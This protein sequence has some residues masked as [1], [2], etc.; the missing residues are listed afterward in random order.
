MCAITPSGKA[1]CVVGLH[2]E[3]IARKP[4]H[5]RNEDQPRL[6]PARAFLGRDPTVSRRILLGDLCGWRSQH[7]SCGGVVELK[8][9]GFG[10]VPMPLGFDRLTRDERDELVDQMAASLRPQWW[11][12]FS[13]ALGVSLAIT[14]AA[15]LAVYGVS[16]R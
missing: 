4:L 3:K 12:N 10:T 2:P 15:S 1:A 16:A 9:E 8:I 5:G 11:A 6:S 13:K 14:L 7:A